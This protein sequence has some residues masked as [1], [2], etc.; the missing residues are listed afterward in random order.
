MIRTQPAKVPN[1]TPVKLPMEKLKIF[2]PA[3]LACC[4][5]KKDAVKNPVTLHCVS[6]K[7]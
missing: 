2:K 3:G 4:T 6:A 5:E 7:P 1:C